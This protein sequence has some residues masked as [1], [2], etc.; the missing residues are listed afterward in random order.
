METII[1]ASQNRGKI[2]EMEAITKEFGMHIL[3]RGEAGVADVEI[4]EDGATFEE[5]S[6]KKARE[7]MKLCGKATIAD[8]SGVMVDALNG[9]P[10]IFSARYAGAECDDKKNRVKLLREME[11]VPYEKRTAKFVSVISM[12]YPCGKEIVARGVC[13]GHIAF[14][15][16]GTGGFGY[17]SLFV[18]LGYEKT[19]AELAPSVKNAVSHRAN[20][21][22]QLKVKLEKGND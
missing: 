11:G 16:R 20:A 13:E 2:M 14:E 18:P 6:L 3:S 5:N 7:I 10:G 19:F 15:E 8:D 12:V 4:I 9:G 17:D 1:A 22:K 21:L